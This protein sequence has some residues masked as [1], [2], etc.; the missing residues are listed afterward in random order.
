MSLALQIL[1]VAA[2]I[3]LL[4][5]AAALAAP[6]GRIPLAL[7]GIRRIMSRDAGLGDSGASGGA[8]A[9]VR[10]ALALLCVLAAAVLAVV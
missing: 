3:A 1:R 8:A 9:P 2:V 7:R 10:R 5:L 4:C 6:P